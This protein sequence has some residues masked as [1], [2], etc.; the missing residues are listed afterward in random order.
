MTTFLSKVARAWSVFA[1]VAAGLVGPIAAR[2]ELAELRQRGITLA[3]DGEDI[4]VSGISSGAGMAHQIHLAYS[5]VVRGA[6]L[7]AGP[8]YRCAEYYLGSTD[9]PPA[10][11]TGEMVAINLC[12]A[13]YTELTL[14]KTPY[15]GGP[16]AVERLKALTADAAERRKIPPT[17]R[18]CNGRAMLINGAV[19]TT[20]PAHIT[21]ATAKLYESLLAGCEG[22]A[23]EHLKVLTVP[24]M[25]HTMPVD[26]AAAA[27]TC[28]A[29]PPYIAEC[30]LKG[31]E[32]I[33]SYLHPKRDAA[34][35][36]EGAAKPENLIAIDQHA[37]IGAT[38]PKWRMHKTGYV[39]VPDRCKSGESC[40]LHVALHGC[41]QNEDQIGEATPEGQAKPLFAR[42]A[43]Y[44]DYAE[45]AG[46][47]VLYPQAQ[48]TGL[49]EGNPNGCWDW[50]GYN[51]PGFYATDAGQPRNIWRIVSELRR[52]K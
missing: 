46:I 34:K 17:E 44:N 23:G 28:P 42:D 32:A 33:L 21:D 31:A 11:T 29:G 3:I 38:Q 5:D 14:L 25:P 27:G 1:L 51:G 30:D 8:P 9:Y 22:G 43:G 18:L 39:Y 52:P 6:G 24:N 45:R 16:I 20:V 7:V 36:A 50:W 19:D 13:Y 2:A 40:A 37:A 47:V 4:A 35:S 15:A 10:M 12:T 49:T 48:Q 41:K 26:A